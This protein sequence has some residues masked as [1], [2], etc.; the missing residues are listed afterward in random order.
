M[1]PSESRCHCIQ[2]KDKWHSLLPLVKQRLTWKLTAWAMSPQRPLPVR[3]PSLAGHHCCSWKRLL[4]EETGP[5]WLSPSLGAPI[6]FCFYI[7]PKWVLRTKNF[8]EVLLPELGG[9]MEMKNHRNFIMPILQRH[10]EVKILVHMYPANSGRDLT[11]GLFG[12][13]WPPLSN[14]ESASHERAIRSSRLGIS[15]A[16]P[17]VIS[18]VWSGP[19]SLLI[20]TPAI[21]LDF[22]LLY[23]LTSGASITPSPSLLS[24]T[25]D[26]QWMSCHLFCSLLPPCSREALRLPVLRISLQV[27]TGMQRGSDRNKNSVVFTVLVSGPW[28]S[29]PGEMYKKNPGGY[30][31]SIF[32]SESRAH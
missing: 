9:K 17:R 8:W 3:G 4:R 21:W 29:T 26:A 2:S 12:P 24:P 7:F 13:R 32:I 30:Q 11:P 23:S 1:A 10:G 18:Q 31:T 16:P 19:P 25:L 22:F 5:S 27:S 28:F 14:G 20:Q 6:A 15:N